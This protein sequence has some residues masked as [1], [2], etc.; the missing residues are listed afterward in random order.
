MWL[1]CLCVGLVAGQM[2]T[3]DSGFTDSGIT[4]DGSTD[5]LPG[6]TDEVVVPETTVAT[7]E[8]TTT[9]STPTPTK[10]QGHSTTY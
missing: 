1:V 5:N 10:G 7:E 2:M 6:Q 9:A 3:T 8:N 4:G